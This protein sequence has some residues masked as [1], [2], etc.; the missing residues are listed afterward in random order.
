MGKGMGLWIAS[1][2]RLFGV[3]EWTLVDVFL[4][5]IGRCMCVS[6]STL[7]NTVKEAV[8]KKHRH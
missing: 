2:A 8:P 7:G 4:Q 1:L 5:A 3:H 6:G